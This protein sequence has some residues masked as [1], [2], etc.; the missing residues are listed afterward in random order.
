MTLTTLKPR[1]QTLGNRLP[2]LT[3][4]PGATLRIRGR[5]W[6]GIRQAVLVKGL[7]ACVDCGKVST[8][9]EID[10]DTPLEQGGLN[11]ES[12]LVIRCI[13]CHKAK[14]AQEAGNRHTDGGTPV[15]S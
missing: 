5:A 13:E 9:N 4:K 14:T 6:M 15:K 7:F 8:D 1:V 12:N 11:H 3:A 2:T 10:H